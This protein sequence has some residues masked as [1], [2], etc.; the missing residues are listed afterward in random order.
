MVARLSILRVARTL[1]ERGFC[2]L[3]CQNAMTPPPRPCHF[4]LVFWL[5]N[6]LGEHERTKFCV[7]RSR[8]A[9]FPSVFLMLD[10]PDPPLF[11]FMLFVEGGDFDVADVTSHYRSK[12]CSELPSAVCLLNKGIVAN[13]QFLNTRFHGFNVHPVFNRFERRESEDRWA[14]FP[15]TMG[16]AMACLY[17]LISYHLST[18]LLKPPDMMQYVNRILARQLKNFTLIY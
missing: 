4:F 7:L 2:V 5:R 17:L 1:K 12:P 8:E 11:T 16:R 18:V 9:R 15:V 10:R 6:A 3:R 13:A 14:F